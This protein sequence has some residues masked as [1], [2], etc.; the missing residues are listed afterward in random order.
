L[1][2]T[3]FEK[4]EKKEGVTGWEKDRRVAETKPEEKS[5]GADDFIEK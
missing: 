2:K 3:P 4:F 5:A 1:E